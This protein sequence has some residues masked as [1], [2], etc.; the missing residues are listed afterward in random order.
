M[1]LFNTNLRNISIVFFIAT[2]LISC[3][4]I[5]QFTPSTQIILQKEDFTIEGKF[6]IKINSIRENGYFLLKKQNNTVNLTLGKNY[7]L[8]E[9]ELTFDYKGL[10]M[11]S[12]LI[13]TEQS[14]FNYKLLPQDLRVE[15]L[16][17]LILGKKDLKQIDSWYIYYPQGIKEINGFQ[18]PQKTL[19]VSGDS[20][21]EFILKKFSLI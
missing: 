11:L 7:F 2:A 18:V 4:A 12:G 1:T 14:N 13:I 3:T 19:L 9:R 8:P 17:S 20:S 15:Q 5:N 10:V 16:I 6:K 21:I